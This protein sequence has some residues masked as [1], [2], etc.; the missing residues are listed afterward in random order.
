MAFSMEVSGM[1]ELLRRMDKLGDKA[2]DAASVALYEGAAVAADAVRQAVNGIATEPFKYAKDGQKRKPS[3]EEK[4]ILMNAQIGIAKF[5]KSLTNVDTSVGIKDKYEKI[6]W[7]HER[8]RTRTKYKVGKNG[9]ARQAAWASS[10]ESS[11]PTYVIANA[12]NS[13]TSFMEKQPFFR[14]ATSRSRAAEAAIE[15][16]LR[17]E[18]DKLGDE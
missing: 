8:T 15:N 2:K 13:G 3:P 17:E 5:R 18:L 7:N 11:K 14:K 6:P 9:K 10:G 16:K 4:E 1:D 12:I